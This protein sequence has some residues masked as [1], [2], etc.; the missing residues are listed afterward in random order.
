[1]KSPIRPVSSGAS[2]EFK[3]SSDSSNSPTMPSRTLNEAGR[4]T[5]QSSYGIDFNAMWANT[6]QAFQRTQNELNAGGLSPLAVSASDSTSGKWPRRD[7]SGGLP[8]DGSLSM[9][10]MDLLSSTMEEESYASQNVSNSFDAMS[11]SGSSKNVT[12]T[13]V[14]TLLFPPPLDVTPSSTR[15]LSSSP[16]PAPS[17]RIPSTL[18]PTSPAHTSQPYDAVSARSPQPSPLSSP[19]ANQTSPFP[20]SV[21]L[22][23]SNNPVSNTQHITP[24]H[25]HSSAR[26]SRVSTLSRNLLAVAQE[27]GQDVGVSVGVQE[28]EGVVVETISH[29]PFS[30]AAPAPTPPASSPH[31]LSF[32]PK[33]RNRRRVVPDFGGIPEEG[34]ASLEGSSEK[35]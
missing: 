14:S 30:T 20:A 11:A 2:S 25:G 34:D 32:P 22:I 13:A 4:N 18:V 31:H 26:R 35:I 28:D 15:S 10:S 6:R 33:Y 3:A 27:V 8:I 16:S 24:V 29:A 9:D 12:K 21:S 23:L 7:S 19:M 17:P 1:M 5:L